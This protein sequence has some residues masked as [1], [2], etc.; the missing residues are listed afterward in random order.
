MQEVDIALIK[1]RSI[2]GIFALT[3][4][5]FAI[6]V[7]GFAAN[8]ILTIF[9]TPAIFGVYFVVSAA[10]AFLSYFSDI[11]LAAALIQ[12]KDE[13]TD[14]EF[15]TTFTIQQILVVSLVVIA[16]FA[17]SFIKSFYHLDEKGIFLFQALIISFFLSSLKTI[18]SIILE[19]NLK[20]EKLVLPQIA[21][22]L[23]FSIIVVVLAIKGFGITSFS[24]A[25]LA[26][27]LIGLITIYIISP[28]KIRLGFS[29]ESAKRLLHFGIPFQANSF[30]ALLKDDLLLAYLGKVLPLAQV[31]FIGFAQKWAFMPLR[32]IMDNVIRITFPS[33]SRLQDNKNLLGK[34]VEKSI[35]ASAFIVFPS[36]VGLVIMSPYFIQIIPRYSKWEPALASLAFFAINAC[37]SSVSTPLT[38]ALNAIG[39]IKISLYLMVFWTIATW[40][41]TPVLIIVMGFNGVGVASAIISL[42]AVFV[43]YLVKKYI[44]FNIVPIF[45]PLISSL[46]MGFLIYILMLML[47]VNAYS[48]FI[49]IVLG[50]ILYF[51]LIFVMAKKMV[52]A[53]LQLVKENIFKK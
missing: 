51:A 20:F 5:T 32:L 31:G 25:V 53:D 22:S 34:A 2:R 41:L 24:I 46:I 1:K 23:V 28:W 49:G 44:D 26:R 36:L 42:S 30:I 17:S 8:F 37:F 19:R 6:Q 16:L 12:K 18:P 15:R 14:I 21:E 7:L 11:G 45:Y 47:K 10:I 38:N 9:L 35:F 39:K 52:L 13:I 43:V 29:K 4:R 50:A 48:I 27:G 33:F 40:V 3:Y